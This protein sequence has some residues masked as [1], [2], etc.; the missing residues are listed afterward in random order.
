[1]VQES[2]TYYTDR[3]H[4]DRLRRCYEIAPPRVQQY[5][6]AEINHLLQRIPPDARVLELGCGYG[7]VLA[8]LMPHSVKVVGID[9]SQASLIAAQ[10]QL[11]DHVNCHLLRM[12]AICLGIADGAFDTVICI[13]NGISAFHVDRRSLLRESIRVCQPGGLVLYSSYADAFW[14]ERL[15]WFRLQAAEG[16]IGPIDESRTTRGTIV[17][18]DGFTATTVREENFQALLAGLDVKAEF[19]EVDGSSLFCEIRVL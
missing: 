3:L 18:T 16:L 9:T 4:A 11:R 15:Q 8:Q 7:R 12:N 13:Q 10:G 1:M 5:L 19:A 2:L 14:E 17:C 6:Q